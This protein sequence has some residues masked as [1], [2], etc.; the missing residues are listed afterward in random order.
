MSSEIYTK[1]K[2]I[3]RPPVKYRFKKIV[4]INLLSYIFEIFQAL[5]IG[6]EVSYVVPYDATCRNRTKLTPQIDN[7]DS[8]SRNC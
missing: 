3:Q 2:V 4:F 5:S 1:M 6:I 8:P 7:L